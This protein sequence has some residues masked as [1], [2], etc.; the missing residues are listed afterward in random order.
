VLGLPRGGVPV[1]AAVAAA[2]GAPL[3]VTLMRKPGIPYQPVIAMGA[4]GEGG[5]RILDDAL[6]ARADVGR[7]APRALD[8]R[9]AGGTVAA[10]RA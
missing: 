10:R 3:D 4:I 8:S 7:G 6:V 2:L 5:V 1:P 9:C